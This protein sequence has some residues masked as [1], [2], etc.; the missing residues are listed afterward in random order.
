MNGYQFVGYRILEFSGVARETLKEVAD[1]L[2]PFE[3]RILERWIE[4]QLEAWRPPAFPLDD[5]R[6]IFGAI[7]HN[8]FELMSACKLEQCIAD[9]SD[10]GEDLAERDFPYEALIFS[11]HFLEESY[12]PFLL[13]P[14][15]PNT[16][17]LLTQMDEFLHAALAS[18][19]TAYFQVNRRR[20]LE[21]AE[22]GRVVQEG[23]LPYIPERVGDL[24]TA[25]VYLSAGE[26][27]QVGGDF[28]GLINL[29]NDRT[30]FLIG[31]L[32]GHGLGAAADAAKLRFMFRGFIR[33][34]GDL[35]SAMEKLNK[36]M[37]A[38]LASGQFATA[39]AGIYEGEG[40]LILVSAGHPPPV[41]CDHDCRLLSPGGLPLGVDASHAFF[42]E[43]NLTLGQGGL[44]V[45]FTDGLIEARRGNEF[46]G[47]ERV[48]ATVEGMKQAPVDII[49]DHLRNE[50]LAFTGGKLLD[51]AA[52]LA[53]R[54]DPA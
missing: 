54:R 4:R 11:M 51:D 42:S 27:A 9:L 48:L 49:V 28:I 5:L 18:I 24:S 30:A 43:F 7:L 25:H 39:L 36:V 44:F 35:V 23:L 47:G 20:L 15:P 38:E 37:A 14:Q 40:R 3:D 32:S 16:L 12:L 50:A 8:M 13:E 22:I 21:Q 46:F 26:K 17:E 10:A 52:I 29:E 19:A 31:D 2:I 6:Q 45:A 34:T 41:V 53:F 33:D 1:R